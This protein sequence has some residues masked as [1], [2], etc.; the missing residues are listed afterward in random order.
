MLEN[1]PKEGW[2]HISTKDLGEAS[3]AC[4]L[5]GTRIRFVHEV[6]NIHNNS[7]L[8]IGCECAA[9]IIAGNDLDYIIEQDKAIRRKAASKKREEERLRKCFE[10]RNEFNLKHGI[11]PITWEG[12]LLL[13][14]ATRKKNEEK[15]AKEAARKGKKKWQY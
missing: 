11:Q 10:A 13:I 3:G 8:Y 2:K 5:C 1:I 9:N 14:E 7:T 6:H 12:Y 4:G 15:A